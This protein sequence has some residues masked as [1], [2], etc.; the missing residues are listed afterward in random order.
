MLDII[1]FALIAFF[2]GYKLYKTLGDTKYDNEISD[3]NKKAFNQFK[4]IILKDAESV[5]DTNNQINIAS[6]TE[7]EMNV[8]DRK[9]FDKIRLSQNNFTA[10]KFL[11]GAKIAFETILKAYSEQSEEVLKTLTSENMF[12]KFKFDIDALKANSQKQ[13]LIVVGIMSA[14]ILS[15]DL[16]NSEVSIKIEF[17]SEQISNTIDIMSNQLIN[18][19]F[20][21][22]VKRIDKWTFAKDINSKSNVWILIKNEH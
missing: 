19:S 12:K 1:I 8:E 22:V 17:E 6:L 15:V 3:E 7:A 5:N 13:N 18:G 9:I 2:I 14:K 20:S 16:N 21:A 10:D 4:E 11:K